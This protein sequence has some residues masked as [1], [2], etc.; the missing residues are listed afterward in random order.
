[1]AQVIVQVGSFAEKD[2]RI[3]YILN[4]L[5]EI[6]KP[7]WESAEHIEDGKPFVGDYEMFNG[8]LTTSL[9]NSSKNKRELLDDLERLSIVLG[10]ANLTLQV[11]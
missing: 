7:K 4:L 1:M 5:A 6:G 8:R 10:Q 9:E 11:V 2:C 3:A